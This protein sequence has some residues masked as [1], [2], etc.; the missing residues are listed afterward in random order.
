MKSSIGSM[1]PLE[2]ANVLLKPRVRLQYQVPVA[3]TL[4]FVYQYQHYERYYR[5]IQRY[6]ERMTESANGIFIH[7]IYELTMLEVEL[8]WGRY[9]ITPR[10]QQLIH[11]RLH[12]TYQDGWGYHLH[13][14]TL[15]QASIKPIQAIKNG[16]LTS[17]KLALD[18]AHL[19]Q[20]I[21]DDIDS[22][23]NASSIPT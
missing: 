19:S 3:E 1:L 11:D 2:S 13:I 10:G 9:K 7:D 20:R 4:H 23:A 21:R 17:G 16:L 18:A 15:G 5:E 14:N 8:M 22:I 6:V 12:S